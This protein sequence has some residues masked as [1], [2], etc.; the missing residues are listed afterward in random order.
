MKVFKR[1][2]VIGALAGAAPLMVPTESVLAAEPA[3]ATRITDDQL[4][5]M[6]SALGLTPDK[7]DQ[8][9]DFAFRA[10]MED[11]QWEL[12]MSAVLSHDKGSVWIMAWLD[13]LPKASADVPRT[14]LLRLLSQNDQLGSGKF[15][16]YIPANRRFVMQ[17]TI[18]NENLTSAQLRIALQDLG[19]SVV[20]TYPIWSVSNWNGSVPA[21]PGAQTQSEG[22][23]P[24]SQSAANE[25]KFEQPVRR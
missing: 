6:I 5:Q 16:A 22:V 14:A 3:D 9:Y 10:Q 21:A 8:R 17:R 20:E 12:S 19:T 13:E 15:F 7:K 1:L 24:A 23:A 11:Q 25:S 2:L 18:P 4:G